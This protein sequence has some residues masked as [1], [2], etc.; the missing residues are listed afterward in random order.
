MRTHLRSTDQFN[1]LHTAHCWSKTSNTGI[2]FWT[3]HQCITK[4]EWMKT[5]WTPK[6]LRVVLLR[7]ELCPFP[8]KTIDLLLR[9]AQIMHNR[10]KQRLLFSNDRKQGEGGKWT[11]YYSLL[12]AVFFRSVF[13]LLASPPP[14]PPPPP[15]PLRPPPPPTPFFSFHFF[16]FLFC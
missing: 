10:S 11:L 4:N 16:F 12:S 7:V 2:V 5:G 6:A 13:F 8:P 14:T 15:L 1:K 9:S 3:F